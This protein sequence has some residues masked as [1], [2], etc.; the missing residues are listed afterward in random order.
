DPADRR[1]GARAL[2]ARAGAR[3]A[4]RA[5][6]QGLRLLLVV[7]GLGPGR[8]ASGH[9]RQVQRRVPR[10]PE[11]AGGARASRK[12]WRDAA[13]QHTAGARPPQ[14]RGLRRPREAR[15]GREDQG[16][17][18]LRARQ[19]C[20]QAAAGTLLQFRTPARG[21]EGARPRRHR[22]VDAAQRVLPLRLQ[23][24]RAQGRRAPPLCGAAIAPRAG[25]PRRGA[26]RLL[27]GEL[28]LA[29]DLGARHP[30]VPRRDDAAR[31]RSA[32]PRHRP[33]HS[34]CG[35]RARLGAHRLALEQAVLVDAYDTLMYARAV[36]TPTEIELLRRSTALN[37]EAI[38]RTVKSWEKGMR[39]RDLNRTY[40]AAVVDLGG[41]V[42]D[43]GAMV[44]GHPRGSEAA[45]TLQTGL[46]DFEVERGMHV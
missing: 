38:E 7:L 13:R 27:P 24:H 41:F 14:S 11:R 34:A 23:R 25:P 37:R 1:L 6:R 19:V 43:P 36:K 21:D 16:R 30:P 4:A 15:Q 2:A 44:W 40:H 9:R 12:A 31:P 33:L 10:D 42:R 22:A 39:W 5:G 3:V 45:L 29:A 26:R 28:P 18:T 32:A 17:L 8:H 46:E 35:E 20:A